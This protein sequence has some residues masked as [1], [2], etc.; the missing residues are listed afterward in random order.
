MYAIALGK[1]ELALHPRHRPTCPFH[2]CRLTLLCFLP[3]SIC[4][5]N[6][7]G[8]DV[9]ALDFVCYGSNKGPFAKFNKCRGLRCKL[10]VP[11]CRTSA[12]G[13]NC[14]GYV[15]IDPTTPNPEYILDSHVV[16]YIGY[17]CIEVA[18]PPR[19]PQLPTLPRININI[20]LHTP[21]A[22]GGGDAAA[23][24]QQQQADGALSEEDEFASGLW[25]VCDC[26]ATH[27]H[28][29]VYGVVVYH[30]VHVVDSQNQDIRTFA[31]P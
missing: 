26:M 25:T 31:S 29:G 8:E 28:P 19:S 27:K 15:A 13:G 20:N 12:F 10:T 9:A 16:R 7:L 4:R 2:S 24:Q 11:G 17:P 18:S 30:V 23:G 5:L 3:S 22:V 1:G 14:V 21:A 6:G